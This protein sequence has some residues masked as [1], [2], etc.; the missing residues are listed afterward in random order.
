[1]KLS[2]AFIK[3][4]VQEFV[5][6]VFADTLREKGF[7]SYKNEDFCWFRVVNH[8]VV[9]HVFFITPHRNYPII[10][11]TSCGFYPLYADID[12]PTS[13]YMYNCNIG[14]PP[15]V[16]QVHWHTGR[17]WPGNGNVM[18]S[19]DDTYGLKMLREKV[20]VQFEGMDSGLNCYKRHKEMR[21]Q[22]LM[23]ASMFEY[24]PYN[25]FIAEMIYQND[26]ELYGEF[27][28]AIAKYRQKDLSNTVNQ[29]EIIRERLA[30][31]DTWQRAITEDRQPFLDEL[32]KRK[33]EFIIKLEKGGIPI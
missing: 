14:V 13:P 23:G 33:A 32:E 6:A 9:H 7:T 8:E 27:L 3:Q 26:S 1:M 19:E 24:R 22:S 16:T 31:L 28:E 20:L 29:P 12:I 15:L 30:Q 2:N 21:L 5:R 4:Q 10:P 17:L 11:F 18:C 25:D